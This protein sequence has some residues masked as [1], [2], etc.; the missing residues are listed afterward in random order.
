MSAARPFYFG[1]CRDTSGKKRI[2]RFPLAH[3]T[4]SSSR[5]TLLDDSLPG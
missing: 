4:A 3:Q 2:E 5:E 1:K